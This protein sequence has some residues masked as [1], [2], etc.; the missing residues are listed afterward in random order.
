MAA[1]RSS[2]AV[3]VA[4]ASLTL[5]TA[6]AL[7]RVFAGRSWLFPMVVAAVA[8]PAFLGWTQRR[9]WPALLRLAVVAVGGLWMSALVVDP[10]TTVVGIPTRATI[11]ALAHALDRT[12]HTLRA[13][14]VPVPPVGSALVLAFLGVFVAAALTAWIATSLDA[15]VGAFAPSVAASVG[16]TR[17]TI[18]TSE[19]VRRLDV[20]ATNRSGPCG[21]R[22]ANS[23]ITVS[24][25]RR[26]CVPIVAPVPSMTSTGRAVRSIADRI[27]AHASTA[28]SNDARSKAPGRTSSIMSTGVRRRASFWRTIR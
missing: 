6:F 1:Q 22:T 8:P 24:R 28:R 12:P 11:S 15:P 14:I 26:P 20:A 5:A 21:S 4:R 9:H 25:C 2:I 10:K 27:D 3:G 17:P 19:A 13:A 23:S 16:W 7:T 18:A